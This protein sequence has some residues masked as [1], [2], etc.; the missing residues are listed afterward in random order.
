MK[1]GDG[2][3]RYIGHISLHPIVKGLR[4]MSFPHLKQPQL[5]EIEVWPTFESVSLHPI[6]NKGIL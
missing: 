1:T 3:G 4:E 2:K 6:P 5:I